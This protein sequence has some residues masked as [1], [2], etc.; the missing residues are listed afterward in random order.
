M[1][2][3]S[4]YPYFK[5]K[6]ISGYIEPESIPAFYHLNYETF[7]LIQAPLSNIRGHINEDVTLKPS[8]TVSQP[9]LETL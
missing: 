1:P 5:V 9:L 3:F 7:C 8:I 6:I 2:A 4:L